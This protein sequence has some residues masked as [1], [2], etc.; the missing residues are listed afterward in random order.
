MNPFSEFEKIFKLATEKSGEALPEACVLSTADKSGRPS[1]R[2]V[3]LR[4][5]SQEGFAF[6]T[7]YESRKAKELSENPFASIVFR[8]AALETQIR[9]EGRVQKMNR[10]DSEA[11]FQSRPR[12]SQV[13]AWASKQS[14]SLSNRTI[15]EKSFDEFDQKFKGKPVP[16]PPNW[17]G[18]LLVP[19]HFEFWKQG[20]HRL[21]YRSVF[22]LSGGS[23][24]SDT[25]Y[26]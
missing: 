15:L 10:K 20:P 23:W 12:E 8:W 18:Y 11:Y 6:Y 13:G 1:A 9:I 5:I 7:N 26:P 4:G 22:R 21:H 25:L 19:D 3:L 16:C 2:Y 24:K 17:G 14:Q